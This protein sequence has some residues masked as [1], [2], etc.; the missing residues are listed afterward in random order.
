[1]SS[2]LSLV[3]VAEPSQPDGIDL[4]CCSVADLLHDMP[5]E[6]TLIIADPPWSYT[7]APGVAHADDQYQTTTDAAIVAALAGAYSRA[8]PGCRLALWTTWPKLGEYL[9]AVRGLGE[10]WR[11]EYKTGGSW[12][13]TPDAGVGYHWLGNSEPVFIYTKGSPGCERWDNLSNA[14][15][16]PRNRHSEKPWGWMAGWLE[17]WTQPGDLVLDLFAGMAP[18]ARACVAT[19]RRYVGAELDPDRYREAVDR[20][21]LFRGEHDTRG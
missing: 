15:Q 9:D 12:H 8:A 11:W 19:G 14:H 6:P 17:R 10:H 4:R 2:Q 16:S 21:A 3:T 18:A 5:G 1:M 20:L 13:K 7:Q